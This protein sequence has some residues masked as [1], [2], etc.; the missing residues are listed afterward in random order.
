MCVQIP[1]RGRITVSTMDHAD[2]FNRLARDILTT[3][4]RIAYHLMMAAIAERTDD[5]LALTLQEIRTYK[6]VAFK[7]PITMNALATTMR[8]PLPTATH[9][10]DSLVAKGIVI[11]TR[12]MHD[13]RLVLVSRSK[14][15]K[16]RE[17]KALDDQA[18]LILNAFKPFNPA[19]WEKIAKALGEVAEALQ[20][21]PKY[22]QGTDGRD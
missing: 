17:Q 5:E 12:T 13:R 7:E 15:A 16:A 14:K 10:V 6:T 19:E 8:I 1:T 2:A 18:A 22:S 9:L 20:S 3:F 4:D 21:R 11:R